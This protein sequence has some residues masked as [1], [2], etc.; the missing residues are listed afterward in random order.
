MTGAPVRVVGALG[1]AQTLA[2]ASSYY[3]PAML[4]APMAADLGVATPTV[5]AAFSGAMVVSA[6][7]GP[8]AGLAIDRHG[9]RVVLAGTSLVFALGL[10]MLGFAQGLWTMVIAWLVIGAAM[11]AGLYEAAFSSLV[12]LYGQHARGAITGITLLAGFASTVGW[13]LSA[14]METR[15]GWRNACLGWAGIHLLI[16]LPLNAWLPTLPSPAQPE[17]TAAADPAQAIASASPSPVAAAGG[18]GY[19]TALLAFVF[20]ATWFI[21]TAMA[22]HLPRMLE[23]AGAT[24]AAAVAVGALVGPAQ[25]AGRVLEFGLLR[26]VHPLLSARLAALAHP[27]GVTVLLMAGPVAAPLFAILHGAGNG[28]LTIAKGTLPLV[29]F[30]AQGYGARQ[31]WLMLPARIAQALAPLL[32]G[33]ALDAWGANALWLSGAI[34]LAACGALM[35]LRG[36]THTH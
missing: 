3:L 21:S 14:W 16:G 19:A 2:W 11:G 32:F 35:L 1:T 33:L 15:F 26:R 7:V 36:P 5:F 29:L 25:V 4:A 20:A 34:G 8:W 17:R 23:A 12:R 31:G 24:L 28:I 22:T 30:G 18:A 6:L 9:G 10:G 13:P 27:A